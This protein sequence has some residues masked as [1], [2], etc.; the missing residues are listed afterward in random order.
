MAENLAESEF[1]DWFLAHDAPELVSPLVALLAHEDC[2]VS[3][4]FLVAGGGRVAR[5]LLAETRG[6]VEPRSDARRCARP[7]RRRDAR[8][9][10]TSSCATACTPSPTTPR[11]WG[12]AATEPVTVAARCRGAPTDV[13]EE[14]ANDH[15]HG[16]AARRCSSRSPDR[17]STPTAT[18]TRR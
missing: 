1:R 11:C 5:T 17:Y 7:L 3:G 16:P 12:S 2:P 8:R 18:S 10:N 6:Y 9:P 4:E 13:T 15:D 14:D